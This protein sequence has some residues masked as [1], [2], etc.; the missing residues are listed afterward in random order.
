MSRDNSRKTDQLE[1]L[2]QQL[3]KYGMRSV[4]FQQNMALKL[5]VS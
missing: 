2:T 3:R 5:G 4:L 1:S